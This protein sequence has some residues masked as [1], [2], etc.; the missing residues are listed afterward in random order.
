VPEAIE[1][2]H[3]AGGVAVWAHPFWDLDRTPEA[4]QTLDTFA[5]A[6]LDG[7]EAFYAAHTA[8][9]TRTLYD[10]ARERGLLT[11]GSADFHGPEHERF[12]AFRAFEL[13]GLEP[14]L[15]PIGR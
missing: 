11:T 14:D 4:L 15:G 5:A 6:G 10:A 12:N 2:I 7:V 9:Q 13:H 1:V 3:A 8:E